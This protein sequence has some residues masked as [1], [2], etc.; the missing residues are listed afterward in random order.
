[1]SVHCQLI[2]NPAA[3]SGQLAAL[4]AALWRWCIRTAGSAGI[5][6]YLDN[7][8]L[9]DLRAGQLPEADQT[10]RL[11]DRWGVRF[12]VRDGAYRDRQAIVESLRREIPAEGIVGVLADG[13]S[14][15]PVDS[16]APTGET[17]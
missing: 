9:A 2:L 10:A 14:W 1:M 11:A 5:Y 6:Q 7:Q 4:G 15:S 16:K 8:A 17:S 13:T 3:T 12:G